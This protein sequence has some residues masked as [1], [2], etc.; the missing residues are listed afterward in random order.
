M[1]DNKERDAML[2]K[3]IETVLGG[4]LDGSKKLVI[5]SEAGVEMVAYDDLGERRV[6]PVTSYR[7]TFKV[8]ST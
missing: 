8:V 1:S 5:D 6:V 4:L 2:E 7:H 3:V